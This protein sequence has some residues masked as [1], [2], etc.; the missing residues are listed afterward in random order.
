[1]EMTGGMDSDVGVRVEAPVVVLYAP[2]A[3]R[4]RVI[5][6]P[7][8]ETILRAIFRSGASS[9]LMPAPDGSSSRR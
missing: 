5:S 4:F 1:M 6:F 7:N 9:A 8:F 2:A 3:C